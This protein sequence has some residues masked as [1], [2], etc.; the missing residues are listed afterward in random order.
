MPIFHLHFCDGRQTFPSDVGIEFPDLEK[1]YLQVCVAIP[2]IARDLLLK[3]Q[4]PLGA[5]YII[6]DGAGRFLMTVPFTD[7]LSPAEWRIAKAR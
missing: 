4:D 6:T 7:V 2:D 1:A 3:R 5:S